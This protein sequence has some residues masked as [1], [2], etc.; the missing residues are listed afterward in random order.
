MKKTALHDRHLKANAKMAPF[1]GWD[2]PIQYAS[3]KDE[4]SAVRSNVGMFDT[5]HMG[6]ALV[7]GHDQLELIDY[8]QTNNFTGAPIGKAVYGLL[9]NEDGGVCDDLI[10]YKIAANKTLVCVN[11][12]NTESDFKIIKECVKEKNIKI[13]FEHLTDYGMIAL[14]GAQAPEA[15]LKISTFREVAEEIKNLKKMS[16]MTIGNIYLARSGYTGEDGFE[17]FAPNNLISSFWDSFDKNGVTKC[18]LAARDVLRIEAAFP[19]YGHEL[20]MDLTPFDADLGKFVDMNKSDFSGKKA[21]QKRPQKF[22]RIL[23]SIT[24][25]IPRQG[26]EIILDNKKVGMVTSGTLR[27]KLN[28]GIGLGLI[29][30][31]CSFS[32]NSLM[33]RVRNRDIPAVLHKRNFLK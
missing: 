18:G 13:D 10:S 14:Q 22:K 30:S 20:S 21:I 11:A 27:A 28:C 7:G 2:M 9:C 24:E 17:I 5:G 15:L 3:I 32:E 19:L 6:I 29:D 23:F 8:I 16:V 12:S 31:N 26:F 4:V 25:S 33:I 1:G